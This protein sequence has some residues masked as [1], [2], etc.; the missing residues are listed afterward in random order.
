MSTESAPNNPPLVKSLAKGL[1][2]IQAFNADRPAMTLSEVAGHTQ[3]PRATARRFLHTLVSLGYARQEGGTFCLT[4]KVL[5]LGY[6]Y[7]SS[8]GMWDVALPIM[9]QLGDQV[10]ESCSAAVLDG[11]E[12]VY[13]A[14]TVSSKRLMSIQIEV[15]SRLP[16]IATSMGRVLLADLPDKRLDEFLKRTPTPKLTDHTI[17]S[18]PA[19]RRTVLQV[20]AQ[21]WALVDQELEQ[22][23]RS[24]AVPI[25]DRLGRATASLNV[26]THTSAVSLDDIHDRILPALQACAAKITEAVGMRQA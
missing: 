18:R 7:L 9:K 15:G 14:R 2:V 10:H 5:D 13:V 4:P 17:V 3:T 6:A 23:L 20:R 25:R 22:G 21:G 26:S 19:L 24:I 11:F 1:A 12:I 8:Q 16:A